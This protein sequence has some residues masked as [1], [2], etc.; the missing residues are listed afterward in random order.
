MDTGKIV[1][2]VA[3]HLK[4]LGRIRIITIDNWVFAAHYRFTT[5]ALLGFATLLGFTQFFGAPIQC[6]KDG[7]FEEKIINNYCWIEGTFTVHYESWNP[8]GEANQ[9]HPGVEAYKKETHTPVAHKYYQWVCWVLLLQ[10]IAFYL[11]RL[12]WKVRIF[13]STIKADPWR[14]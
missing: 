10:A 5:W 3:T 11:P 8:R 2:I 4:F 7:S 6:I 1:A 12:L 14:S 9:A 13:S